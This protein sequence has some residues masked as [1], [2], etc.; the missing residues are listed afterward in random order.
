L[1]RDLDKSAAFMALLQPLQRQL[2]VYCRRMLRDRSL[3]ED[4]LQAAVMAAFSQFDR[5]AGGRHRCREGGYQMVSAVLADNFVVVIGNTHPETLDKLLD[6][7]GS[8]H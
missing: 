3:V 8:Y 7:Y 5:L 2:E 1:S 4:V 6:A